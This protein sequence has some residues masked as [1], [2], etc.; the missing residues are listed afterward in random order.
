MSSRSLFQSIMKYESFDRMPVV[1]W[2]GWPETIVRWHKEG[3]PADANACEFFKADPL[4]PGVPVNVHLYPL[5]EE[6]VLEETSE[7]RLIRQPDG[8]VAQHFLGRSSIPHFVDFTMKDREGWPEYQKRLQPDPARVPAD[9][10]DIIARLEAS[11]QPLCVPTGSL[12]GWIRDW[13]GVENFC[14]Q[15]CIDPD[16]IA[17][18]VDTMA[19]LTC[20]GLEQVLPKVRVDFGWGWEDIC[21]KSGPLVSPVLFERIMVPAYRRIADTLKKYGCDLYAVDC[22]GLIDQLLPHWLD[23]GVNVMFPLEIGSWK[24]DPMSYRKKYGKDLRIFGGIDKLAIERGRD[25]IDEEIER[26]KPLMADGGFIPMPDHLITP[27]T[28]LDDY[29]YYLDRMR[30][31]RF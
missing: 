6:Q 22:D 14:M 8:V 4:P 28:A 29:R 2:D 1:H 11:G 10:D 17:E 23:A 15:C 21:F 9:L 27:D 26:R 18:I 13:M 19:T 31:L 5:F 12:V 7:Y 20:W 30:E 16:L 24:A 25:A 3:L